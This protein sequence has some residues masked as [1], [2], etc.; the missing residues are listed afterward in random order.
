MEIIMRHQGQLLICFVQ[1]LIW[2]SLLA[3]LPCRVLAADLA[4]DWV[5][6]APTEGEAGDAVTLQAKIVNNGPDTAYS[7]QVQWYLSADELISTD[8]MAV[9]SVMTLNEYLYAGD[10]TIVTDPITVPAFADPMAP[11][12]FGL[13][14]YYPLFPPYDDDPDNNTGS[15]AFTFIG[16]PPHSFYDTVGDNYLD[17]VHL[18]ATVSNGNLAVAITFSE[19]PASTISLL[20]G[21]DLDQ[22]SVTTGLNTTMPGTEAMLSLV[23]ENLT[24]ESVVSMENETGSHT[25]AGAVL[26]GNTLTYS[27]PLSLLN[28][29][30]AMDLFWAI[31]HAVGPTADFDRAPDVGAYSTDSEAV[32]V[33][34]PGDATIQV[35]VADPSPDPGGADFPD[36]QQLDARVVGDQLHLALTYAHS[37][38]VMHLPASSDGLFVWVDMDS[39][40]RLATGFAN[41]GQTPPTMGID[42]QLR[43]QID[44][45]AGI[46]SELLKDT[47]GNGEPEV[48]PMG[49]PFNDMFMRLDNNRILLRIPLAYMGNTDGS[50]AMAVTSLNTREILTGIIDRLPDSGAWDL[51]NDALLPDQACLAASREVNDPDDDSLYGAGGWDNDEL[52]HAAICLGDQALLF[53]IDYDSYLLSNDGATLIHLDTDRNPD[54]GLAVTNLAGGTTIGADYVLRSYW[55]YDELKQ[56]T[57]LHRAVPPESVTTVHQLATP[58]QANR[59]YL[60]L[61]LESIGLP[62]GPVDILVRTA[63]WAGPGSSILLPN[64]D[65]PDAGVVTLMTIPGGY[66]GDLDADGDVDGIDLVMFVNNPAQMVLGDFVMDFG[67][68]ELS[69]N[70]LLLAP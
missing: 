70:S 37:V 29:D 16:D 10:S 38:D 62:V 59:L 28:N 11:S 1:V 41:T 20:M 31:D 36:I 43:L 3:F 65:L 33:R 44:D 2:V 51:K 46:V 53:A 25:L 66:P 6:V 24:A 21:I 48:F 9:G 17:A 30:S 42:H 55:D 50:G 67:K 63:S 27:V 8:D 56:T 15:A 34:L 35:S 26:N 47:D 14:I 57:R 68:A 5:T 39:D 58:T 54:T 12:Y 7:I 64:D 60:A 45:L 69:G 32:V 52:V 18:S 19:P 4:V 49:L 22:D 61:P 13:M 23:Y 40:G